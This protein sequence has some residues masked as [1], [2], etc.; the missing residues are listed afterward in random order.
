MC[1]HYEPCCLKNEH[2]A[3]ILKEGIWVKNSLYIQN[4]MFDILIGSLHFLYTMVVYPL[5]TTD[6]PQKTNVSFNIWQF[7]FLIHDN[8]IFK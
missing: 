2:Y 5:Q 7:F 3:Q 1:G 6:N 4:I 8:A